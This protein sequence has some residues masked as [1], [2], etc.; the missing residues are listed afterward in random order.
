M[1]N[2][3][4]RPY[5]VLMSDRIQIP[6]PSLDSPQRHIYVHSILEN[7]HSVG[8]CYFTV[9]RLATTTMDIRIR[10]QTLIRH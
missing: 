6:S 8:V 5:L 2:G 3:M 4:K 1:I 9:T 10:N 7:R